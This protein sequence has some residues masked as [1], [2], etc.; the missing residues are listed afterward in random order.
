MA[1][2]LL[3][4]VGVIFQAGPPAYS[5]AAFGAVIGLLACAPFMILGAVVVISLVVTTAAGLVVA[6]P[7]LLV[8]RVHDHV[9]DRARVS[10]QV[11]APRVRRA[12]FAPAP[13]MPEPR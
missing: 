1:D 12:S 6:A 8:R 3:P 2:D 13:T 7:L 10:P 11:V 9:V 4:V 5:V